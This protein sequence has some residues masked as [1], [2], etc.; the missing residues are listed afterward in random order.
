MPAWLEWKELNFL[1]IAYEATASPL[2]YTPLFNFQSSDHVPEVREMVGY[3][4]FEPAI[5]SWKVR[6]VRPLH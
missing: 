4:G 3:A 6:C 2:S 1:S 5:F